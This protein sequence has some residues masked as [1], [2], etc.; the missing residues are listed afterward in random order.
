MDTSRD[1]YI[2]WDAVWLDMD[3]SRDLDI[4]W[5]NIVA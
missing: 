5:D 4:T 3:T 1:L 2:T